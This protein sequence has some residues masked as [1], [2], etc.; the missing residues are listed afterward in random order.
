M[1]GITHPIKQIANLDIFAKRKTRIDEGVLFG[2]DSEQEEEHIEIAT[3]HLEKLFNTVVELT[4]EEDP[5]HF[6]VMRGYEFDG[7]ADESQEI[8]IKPSKHA[9]DPDAKPKTIQDVDYVL[10]CDGLH[11]KTR[12]DAEIDIEYLTEEK[13]YIAAV[14]YQDTQQSSRPGFVEQFD[15]IKDDSFLDA[16]SDPT[17]PIRQRILF[18]PL[19]AKQ[20]EAGEK[21]AFHSLPAVR[22]FFTAVGTYIGV[23]ITPSHLEDKREG[24]RTDEEIIS[25]QCRAIMRIIFG[26][27]D[28]PSRSPAFKQLQ[29]HLLR[30]GQIFGVRLQ[31]AQV[32]HKVLPNGITYIPLGDAHAN[33][34]FQ[35][36]SGA[37][38]G[39]ESARGVLE[40]LGTPD[41]KLAVESILDSIAN[42]LRTKVNH[43]YDVNQSARP[44]SPHPTAKGDGPISASGDSSLKTKPKPPAKP[45]DVNA[46]IKALINEFEQS[47]EKS[48]LDNS[49]LKASTETL[50]TALKARQQTFER[51]VQ[52]NP[53]GAFNT[54]TNGCLD[55]FEET[56]PKL[57]KGVRGFFYD[58][59]VGFLNG[60]KAI[61]NLFAKEPKPY[62]K[63][64][65]GQKSE[66]E[67]AIDTYRGKLLDLNR[68]I[69][70]SE[71][72]SVKAP[73]TG[74]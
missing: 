28:N 18:P 72:D 1:G 24:R 21:D 31:E 44:G 22:V 16:Q 35:T 23:E 7:Y 60:L 65:T 17:W 9:T 51:N 8:R 37:L 47:I 63:F 11:S 39:I 4:S 19:P 33:A 74:P 30:K 61:Y 25:R 2:S 45:I 13:T 54:F 69:L 15:S 5:D 73:S 67:T 57:D 3:R 6:E 29:D 66:I 70:D 32:K 59:V 62:G 49:R 12:E 50:F 41:E 36:G 48:G 43:F 64:C 10:G 14:Y 68:E 52:S 53:K 20:R 27:F 34:H 42:L 56:E 58:C 46:R 26:V 71:N 40:Q 55:A 38:Y